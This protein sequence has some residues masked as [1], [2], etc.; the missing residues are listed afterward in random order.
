MKHILILITITFFSFALL[1]QNNANESSQE[2]RLSLHEAY[3]YALEHNISL[4]NS[5]LEIRKAELKRWQTLATML[6]Q[7]NAAFDYQNFCGHELRFSM[8]SIPMNP[9]G[10]TSVTAS[11]ALSASQMLGSIVNSKL[12]DI[13]SLAYRQSEQQIIK[14]L[15][16]I[17]ASILVSESSIELL[18]RS[19]ANLTSLLKIAENSVKVGVAEQTNVDQLSIQLSN[20]KNT[21]NN[22][23]R[24]VEM[25]YNTLILQLGSDT[26]IKLKLTTDIDSILDINNS[27]RLLNTDFNISNNYNYQLLEKKTEI[28]KVQ[29]DLTIASYFPTITGFYQYSSKSYFGKEEGMNMTPPNL[30]GI[31]VKLPIWS[32]GQRTASLQEANLSYRI[33]QQS[34]KDVERSLSVQY[35]QLKYNLKSAIETYDLQKRAVE[36]SERVV[37]N[38]SKKFEFGRVSSLELTNASSSLISAQSNYVSSLLEIINARIELEQLLNNSPNK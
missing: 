24:T 6:P 12:I 35:K 33:A 11:V 4:Q 10:T 1:G 23:R 7:V 8:V 27:T 21:I 14:Q 13:Q 15:T 20:V 19:A 2:L 31:S 34:L 28:S 18:E 22:V 36:T 5:S 3:T 25:L 16:K 9:T 29:K 32:S 38:I 26:N 30:V 37:E 17:Y